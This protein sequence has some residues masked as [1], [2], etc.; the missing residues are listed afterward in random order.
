ML[1]EGTLNL[2]MK[3]SDGQGGEEAISKSKVHKVATDWSRDGKFVAVST[4]D[5]SAKLQN[6][7]G[8]LPMTGERTMKPFLQTSFREV[9]PRFSPDGRWVA[10]SSDESGNPAL[11]VTAFPGPGGKYQIASDPEES[12]RAQW[13]PGGKEI[14]YLA[15]DSSM[16][17]VTVIPRGAALEIGAPRPLFKAPSSV[18][19]WLLDREGKRFL[20][21]RV[22]DD[23]HGAPI[24]L[25]THWTNKLNR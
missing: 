8:V 7:I 21:G 1:E 24:T 15:R 18:S 10:Y 2:F 14:Y 12:L 23:S 9:E 17:A 22:P 16:K 25:M 11:Y 13:G 6:D 3:A 5:P 4:F 20:L 19:F